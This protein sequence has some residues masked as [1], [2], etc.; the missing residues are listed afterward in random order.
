MATRGL[1]AMRSRIKA[2]ASSAFSKMPFANQ[3][4]L[5]S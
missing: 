3:F 5:P 2:A 4:S 1:T